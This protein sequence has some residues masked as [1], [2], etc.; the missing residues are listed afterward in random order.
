VVLYVGGISELFLS[1]PKEE[2]VFLKD[3][4]GFIKLAVRAGADVIPVYC[5]GN[6]LALE[7]LQ[8]KFLRTLSRKLGASIT[9]MFGLWGLPIPRPCKLLVVRGSPLGLPQRDEPT[10]QEI[11]EWHQKYVDEV[12]KLFEKYKEKHPDYANKT[13]YVE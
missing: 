12:V 1:N 13:L 10:Q 11:D 2:R 7:I 9:L 6:T 8:N 3:R 4:K 5:F